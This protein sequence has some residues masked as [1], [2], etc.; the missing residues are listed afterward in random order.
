M[1]DRDTRQA[2]PG[3]AAA[4]RTRR[5]GGE[6]PT[7]HEAGQDRASAGPAHE[8][9][10]AS[11]RHRLTGTEQS[12]DRARFAVGP[13]V[14]FE[15]VAGSHDPAGGH[16]DRVYVGQTRCER[17]AHC[18]RRHIH[19]ERERPAGHVVRRLALDHRVALGLEQVLGVR[20]ERLGH[21]DNEGAG[22]IPLAVSGEGRLGALHLD[23]ALEQDRGEPCA[24]LRIA[25]A[26]REEVREWIALQPRLDRALAQGDEAVEERLPLLRGQ[27]HQRPGG[28][29]FVARDV[30]D[31]PRAPRP[32]SGIVD[33]PRGLPQGVSRQGDR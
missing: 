27:T 25:G 29:Q 14:Q 19:G 17:R 30:A 24:G 10:L 8:H 32:G 21:R 33:A 3:N 13:V 5:P 11:H 28:D 12:R 20:P 31:T 4:R 16:H 6:P 23:A 7:G 9:T 2:A 18:N 15:C 26:G 22:G 1:I